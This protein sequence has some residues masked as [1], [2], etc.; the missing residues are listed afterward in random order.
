ME[1]KET[2]GAGTAHR[3]EMIAAQCWEEMIEIYSTN[4]CAANL[5]HWFLLRFLFNVCGNK[6]VL[7]QLCMAAGVK[8]SFIEGRIVVPLKGPLVF[9]RL[10]KSLDFFI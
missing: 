4:V 1:E 6:N 2:A 7:H 9:V 5:H 10:Q 8:L 3:D